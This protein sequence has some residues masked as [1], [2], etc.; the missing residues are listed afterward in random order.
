M[1]IQVNVPCQPPNSYP[2][3]GSFRNVTFLTT[4]PWQHLVTPQGTSL[5][6]CRLHFLSINFGI[7]EFKICRKFA[8]LIIR[9]CLAYRPWKWLDKRNIFPCVVGNIFFTKW[10]VE[11]P[12]SDKPSGAEGYPGV[13]RF[14][15]VNVPQCFGYTK[16][17][18]RY[19]SVLNGPDTNFV[20]SKVWIATKYYLRSWWHTHSLSPT[21]CPTVFRCS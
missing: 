6:A 4:D 1:K 19:V 11:S 10:R 17:F 7:Q 13:G 12:T 16:C 20:P 8:R 14:C 3:V 18:Y 21:K 5:A 2:P 15:Y 9:I